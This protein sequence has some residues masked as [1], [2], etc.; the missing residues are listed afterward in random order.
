MMVNQRLDDL[1]R[2]SE[3]TITDVRL[4][5][6]IAVRAAGVPPEPTEKDSEIISMRKVRDELVAQG[7]AV[8]DVHLEGRGYDLY[9][10]RGQAQRCVEV[11]GVWGSA[12]SQGIR[13]TGNEILIATQHRNDYWLYVVD[14]CQNGAGN[15]F[16]I[17][18]DPVATF[19]GLIKQD[20][21]FTVPGSALKAARDQGVKA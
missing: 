9:A 13:L 10:T 8:A 21:I 18:R 1:R 11:K 4:A 7:F 14:T 19:E 20:A 17:Y 2:M 12:S 5:A 3:V 15:V 6:H 16:G